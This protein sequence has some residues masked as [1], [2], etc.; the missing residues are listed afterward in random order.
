VLRFD[1]SALV[2]CLAQLPNEAR[3]AFA[4]LCAERQLP[5]YERFSAKSGTGNP[6]TLKEALLP[7][8]AG[9]QGRRASANELEAIL[10]RCMALIPGEEDASE[11]AAYADDAVASVAYTIR[12][13]LTADPQEAAWAARRAYD[14]VDHFIANQLNQSI[15]ERELEGAIAAHPLVQ[16]EL[17]R[18]Q[19]D[20]RDLQ[21]AG[22]QGQLSEKVISSLR[23]RARR[24]AE[25]FL[26]DRS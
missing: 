20:L 10:G 15:I 24:D 4:A 1:E 16:A 9:L 12:A 26:R 5:N 25:P 22:A 17:Q 21:S 8:W 6:R 19:A 13:L 14:A 18:Q 2:K 3:V 11:E 7:I 23:D